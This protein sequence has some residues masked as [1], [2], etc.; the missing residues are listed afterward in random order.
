ML[1][2]DPLAPRTPRLPHQRLGALAQLAASTALHVAFVVIAASI[3]TTLAPGIDARRPE[4]ITDLQGQDVRLVFLVSELPRTAGGGGGGG[5]QRP[6]PIR[7]AQGVGADPITLRVQR[8]PPPTAPVTAAVRTGGRG[9]SVDSIDRARCEA[10]GLRLLRSDWIAGRRRDVRPVD[11]SRIRGRRRHRKRDRHRP[12]TWP[13]SRPRIRRWNWRWRLPPGR[14]RIRTAPD[15][16]GQAQVHERGDD[17]EDSRH[18]P[19]G[20]HRHCAT[21]AR[22][23]SVSSDRSTPGASIRKP[24]RPLPN[25]GS[26]LDVLGPRR[27]MCSSRST[28]ASGF[29]EGRATGNALCFCR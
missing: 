11:R 8:R 26:S 10:A 27:S 22:R 24:W 15:Q 29:A 3:A 19:A 5:N 9:R 25:G 23:R 4:P 2:L 12:G 21:D 14:G 16:G 13:R 6:E 1:H 20:S 18:G 7:R 17:P 28:S